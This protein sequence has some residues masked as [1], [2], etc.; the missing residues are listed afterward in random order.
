MYVNENPS[1]TELAAR[2]LE[3]LLAWQYKGLLDTP[4][5]D[6]SHSL[7]EQTV[8][9]THTSSESTVLAQPELSFTGWQESMKNCQDCGL[10]AGRA[11]LVHGNGNPNGKL[12]LLLP[13]ATAQMEKENAIYAGKTG[14]L[15]TKMLHA[16]GLEPNAVFTTCVLKC[17]PRT[18]RKPNEIEIDA[19]QN[20]FLKE[21]AFIRPEFILAM[22][23]IPA[24]TL[25]RTDA[26]VGNLRGTWEEF[27]GVPLLCTWDADTLLREPA[28]KKEA[29][30][31]L[32][33]LL[34][35]MD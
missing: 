28:K 23:D 15:L 31:D 5:L 17:A 34:A 27:H 35:R 20:H 1:E 33:M 8:G 26:P 7:S 25:L 32:K 13:P 11:R 14:A 22:G 19:C 6:L 2:Q 4:L 24:Q 18:G 16:I 29:W 21:L 30:S 3:V 9:L 12:L 10:H